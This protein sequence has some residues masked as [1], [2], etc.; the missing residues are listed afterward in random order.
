MADTTNASERE[1]LNVHHHDGSLGKKAGVR[2]KI[3]SPRCS[4]KHVGRCNANT[5]SCHHAQWWKASHAS[6]DDVSSL[7]NAG[8][9]TTRRIRH[10]HFDTGVGVPLSSLAV[11]NSSRGLNFHESNCNFGAKFNGTSM[12]RD[13]ESPITWV[14][15]APGPAEED[16]EMQEDPQRFDHNVPPAFVNDLA[17]RLARLGFDPDDADFEVP[18]RTWYLDHATVRR[19][20]APRNLQLV[21]PPQGWEMQF[22]S[23][24][25][26]QI[27]P[28]EWYDLTIITPDP[29]RPYALRHFVLDLVIT[30][31]LD[32]PRFAGLV[33]IMPDARSRFY[34]YSVACSFDAHISGFDIIN[35]AD[36]AR[37]CRHQACRITFGW[38]EIPNTLRPTHDTS[39]GDGFQIMIR[40]SPT[41]LAQR[42]ESSSGS[43]ATVALP[44]SRFHPQNAGTEAEA[45]IDSSAMTSSASASIASR[46]AARFMTALHLY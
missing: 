28:D 42:S 11:L 32:L 13:H 1:V 45:A 40:D 38:Q 16:D 37:V 6:P 22:S 12:R 20:T 9:Q 21:G 15:G 23:L 39:H 29:P 3:P 14:P 26:D 5:I 18:V 33:T 35:A 30:Q 44:D 41:Q 43:S 8:V 17:H 36:I 46:S 25:V 34:L 19:W 2:V 7:P 31:S 10:A 4:K 27:D 24:W